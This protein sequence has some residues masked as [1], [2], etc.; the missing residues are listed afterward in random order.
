MRHKCFQIQKAS[1]I[2]LSIMT[3]IMVVIMMMTFI[4][5]RKLRVDTWTF[6]SKVG[7][8]GSRGESGS[9]EVTSLWIS[10]ASIAWLPYNGERIEAYRYSYISTPRNFVEF[11]HNWSDLALCPLQHWLLQISRFP[12]FQIFSVV[13]V[14]EAVVQKFSKT[15]PILHFVLSKTNLARFPDHTTH[16]TDRKYINLEILMHFLKALVYIKWI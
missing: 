1:L 16:D 11:Q 2:C 9:P 13:S 6:V 7:W 8:T 14:W 15:A 5:K 3:T 4:R 10:A 12:D